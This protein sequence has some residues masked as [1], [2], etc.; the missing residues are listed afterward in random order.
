VN[1][2]ELLVWSIPRP[3]ELNREAWKAI[4]DAAD[5]LRDAMQRDDIPAVIG[6]A[7][8]LCETVARVILAQRGPSVGSNVSY[9]ELITMAHRAIERQPGEGVAGDED[10]RKI[11]RSA[12]TIMAALGPMRN[13]RGTGHGRAEAPDV[14][15]EHA[16]IAGDAAFLWARWALRRLGHYMLGDVPVLVNKLKDDTFRRGVLAE[17]LR[18]VDLPQRTPDEARLLGVSVGQRAV[19]ETFLVQEEGVEAAIAAPDRWS[20]TYRAGVIEGL[21]FSVDGTVT[22]SPP[23]VDSAAR[24]LALQPDALAVIERLEHLAA[25]AAW[26]AP[27]VGS[28]PSLDEVTEAIRRAAQRLPADLRDPW[29]HIG[30]AIERTQAGLS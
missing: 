24:L 26:T 21:L 12:K 19:R 22:S 25:T 10:V 2:D 4:S 9:D 8:E 13:Q 15:A 7:K 30:A 6:S 20:P 18:A 11:A 28:P 23:A 14:E 3:P 27:A 29:S 16:C 1:D 17:R 5:R